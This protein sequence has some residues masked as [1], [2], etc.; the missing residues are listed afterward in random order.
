MKQDLVAI[1][2][3]WGFT[4]FGGFLGAIVS[5]AYMPGLTWREQ[6][7]ATLAGG[8]T[9]SFVCWALQDWL[10]LSSAVAGGLSFVVGLVAFRATPSLVKAVADS[11]ARV[12]DVVGQLGQALA[13]RI[14]TFGGK[15]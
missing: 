11:F 4:L 14:R 12:P 2:H 9:A 10:H 7:A 15:S 13:D 5:L 3:D 6:V 8:F 1:L